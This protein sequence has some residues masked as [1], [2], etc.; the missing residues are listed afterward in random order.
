M[1]KSTTWS[2]PQ[3]ARI[4]WALATLAALSTLLGAPVKW[5]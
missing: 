1:R 4:A 5:N 2:R 3:W